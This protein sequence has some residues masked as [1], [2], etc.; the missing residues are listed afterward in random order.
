MTGVQTCALPI[1]DNNDL[2]WR[3]VLPAVMLLVALSMSMILRGIR[4]ARVGAES[5]PAGGGIFDGAAKVFSSPYFARIALFVFLAN[6]VGTFFYNE[7]LRL[8]GATMT[9]PATRVRF[10][11]DRDLLVS[12]ATIAIEIFGTAAIFRRFGVT[13]A[14]IA[15]PVVAM[16]GTLALSIHPILWMAAAVMVAERVTAFALSSPA[17]K[18]MYTQTTPDEKYKV[19]NF[20][21]T[22]VYRGGDAVSGWLFAM[23]SGGVGFASAWVPAVALPLAFAWY[24]TAH[25]MGQSY[26]A[27]ESLDAK[28]RI[29]AL[30]ANFSGSG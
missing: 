30:K 20:V 8:V 7:Q 18:V 2:G 22:V 23:L 27:K 4:S 24:H 6:I 9:D 29:E 28:Q 12:V 10:F 13:G 15:L 17:I 1:W 26:E 21:D 19:Q 11:A 16:L 5:K 25:K 14:L 3:A